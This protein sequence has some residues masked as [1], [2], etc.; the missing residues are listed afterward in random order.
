M[1][2]VVVMANVGALWRGPLSSVYTAMQAGM[3]KVVMEKRRA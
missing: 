3:G 1:V 2:V